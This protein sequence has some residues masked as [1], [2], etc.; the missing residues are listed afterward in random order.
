MEPPGFE[1]HREEAEEDI[2]HVVGSPLPL[3]HRP[4][5]PHQFKVPMGPKVEEVPEQEDPKG[6]R[7]ESEQEQAESSAEEATINV[8]RP[9]VYPAHF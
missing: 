3:P 9:Y 2:A 7:G 1:H 8:P 5:P 4:S 6:K